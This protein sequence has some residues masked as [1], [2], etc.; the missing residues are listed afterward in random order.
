MLFIPSSGVRDVGV[1]W[2]AELFIVSMGNKIINYSKSEGQ[3][4]DIML[5][6]ALNA[7][8]YN[9]YHSSIVKILIYVLEGTI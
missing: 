5:T 7:A 9:H 8:C 1:K 6:L 4:A 2:H 3:Q